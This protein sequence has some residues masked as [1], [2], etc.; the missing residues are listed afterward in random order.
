[1]EEVLQLSQSYS[2][3]C[4]YNVDIC[5]GINSPEKDIANEHSPEQKQYQGFYINEVEIENFKEIE[6]KTEELKE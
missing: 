1:M 3:L 2:L 6:E 4:G 5:T